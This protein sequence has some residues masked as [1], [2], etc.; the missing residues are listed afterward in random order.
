MLTINPTCMSYQSGTWRNDL[1]QAGTYQQRMAAPTEEPIMAWNKLPKSFRIFAY[2]ALIVTAA[3]AI[4]L[5]RENYGTQIFNE[6]TKPQERIEQRF[7]QPKRN[8]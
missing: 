3:T 4:S 7:E 6:L 1:T 5:I 2:G 8:L